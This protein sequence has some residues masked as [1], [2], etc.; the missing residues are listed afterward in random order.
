MIQNGFHGLVLLDELEGRLGADTRHTGDIVARVAHKALKID[1][2]AGAKAFV[3]FLEG[4]F[5]VITN[6][7]D[8]FLVK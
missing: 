4:R 6:L 1:D 8:A 7:G 3:F 2:L 5:V